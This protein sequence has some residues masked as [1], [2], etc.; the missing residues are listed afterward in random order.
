MKWDTDNKFTNT[1][2]EM[3]A[4][5]PKDDDYLIINQELAGVSIR[6]SAFDVFSYYHNPIL[7]YDDCGSS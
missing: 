4:Y 6:M 5:Y 7:N 1:T 3:S 2:Y